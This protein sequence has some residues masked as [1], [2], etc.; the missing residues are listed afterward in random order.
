MKSTDKD[1]PVKTLPHGVWE[2]SHPEKK[3]NK[4]SSPSTDLQGNGYPLNKQDK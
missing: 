1:K 4:N 2:S 3:E